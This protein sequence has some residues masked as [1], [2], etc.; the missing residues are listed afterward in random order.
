MKR[1]LN[2]DDI[3]IKHKSLLA[4][5]SYCKTNKLNAKHLFIYYEDKKI[6]VGFSSNKDLHIQLTDDCWVP[7]NSDVNTFPT[8]LN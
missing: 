3:K 5:Q 4:I 1:L 8:A 2:L 6:H 7:A